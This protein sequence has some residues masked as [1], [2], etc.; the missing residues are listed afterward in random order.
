MFTSTCNNNNPKHVSFANFI[1]RDISGIPEQFATINNLPSTVT[2]VASTRFEP[3]NFQIPLTRPYMVCG[4]TS[5]ETLHG[6][7]KS[8]TK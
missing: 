4:T 3:N 6:S 5:S 7:F 2:C 1:V 8:D